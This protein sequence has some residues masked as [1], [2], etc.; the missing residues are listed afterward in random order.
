M[1]LF[2]TLASISGYIINDCYGSQRKVTES[3]RC[4]AEDSAVDKL[5][6]AKL[7]R[8]AFTRHVH[9]GS[10]QGVNEMAEKVFTSFI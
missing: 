9:K 1:F 8:P 10:P 6:E 7:R 4:K 2:V 5:H 3:I